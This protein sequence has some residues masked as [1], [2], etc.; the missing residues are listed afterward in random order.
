M[1]VELI[2]TKA[3]AFSSTLRSILPNEV[4]FTKAIRNFCCAI[5]MIFSASASPSV[6]LKRDEEHIDPFVLVPT[7]FGDCSFTLAW[8]LSSSQL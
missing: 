4:I 5:L 3:S 7:V 2:A 6:N 8:A 1:M